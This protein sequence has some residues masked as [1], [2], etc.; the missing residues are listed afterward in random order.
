MRGKSFHIFAAVLGSAVVA[1]CA[2]PMM[3]LHGRDVVLTGS[4]TA[5]GSPDDATRIIM[6]EASRITLD[7]G[8][9]YFEILDP[10]KPG[11]KVTIRLYAAGE[12]IPPAA[13]V[14]NPGLMMLNAPRPKE[15]SPEED[16]IE[17]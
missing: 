4:N 17:H 11:A 3:Q 12:S 1:N 16:M 9:S 15:A 14:Y 2:H 6:A 10:I 13:K 7:H 5:Q 8:Y